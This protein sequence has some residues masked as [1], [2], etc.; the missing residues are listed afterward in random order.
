MRASS[1]NTPPAPLLL[2]EKVRNNMYILM[3]IP[4][5]LNHIQ[6]AMKA[7]DSPI[8]IEIGS[9]VILTIDIINIKAVP[10]KWR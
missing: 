1:L 5:V 6:P 9:Q 4:L 3:N 8:T 7:E 10:R 2:L